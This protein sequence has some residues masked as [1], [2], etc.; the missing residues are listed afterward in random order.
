MLL[1]LRSRLEQLSEIVLEEHETL[2]ASQLLIFIIVV[3]PMCLKK[4]LGFHN[5]YIEMGLKFY[6]TIF[7]FINSI[8]NITH[9][10]RYSAPVAR[11]Y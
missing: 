4:V 7:I 5:K 10:R 2:N 6:N 11:R 1:G 8:K 9:R 3:D